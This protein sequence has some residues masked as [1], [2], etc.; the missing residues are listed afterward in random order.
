MTEVGQERLDALEEQRRINKETAAAEAEAEAIRGQRME[1][2]IEIDS[3]ERE[4]NNITNW[5]RRT[6]CETLTRFN[7]KELDNIY[8]TTTNLYS[9][10][11]SRID[12]WADLL[13]SNED[14]DPIYPD[15]GVPEYCYSPELKDFSK[16]TKVMA[17]VL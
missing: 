4:G 14:R 17:K 9:R 15:K 7:F 5:L 2:I 6:S 16:K 8:I 3:L 12:D 13:E 10:L 1:L 11:N